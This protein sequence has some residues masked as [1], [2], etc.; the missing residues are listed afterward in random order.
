V[1][2]V[3]AAMEHAG[4]HY[5]DIRELQHAVGARLS[6]LMGS[7]AAMV[8]NGCA[9][10]LAHVAA[11]CLAGTDRAKQQLLP[12]TEGVLPNEVIVQR[13]HRFGYDYGVPDHP[14]A[15]RPGL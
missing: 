12:F 6:E 10:A 15:C 9:A 13:C 14:C 4:L 7:E 2:Q 3:K 11:G 8:T 5:V 1:R